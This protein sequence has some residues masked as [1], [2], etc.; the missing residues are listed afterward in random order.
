MSQS[1]QIVLV[2]HCGPDV[3]RLKTAV[4]RAVPEAEIVTVDDEQSLDEYRTPDFLW[5][6]NRILDGSFTTDSGIELIRQIRSEPAPADAPIAILISDLPGAQEE[7]IAAGAR[8]GFGKS[9]ILE[10][11]TVEILREA[12]K[13]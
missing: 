12:A 4:N 3:Y 2:G 5:L 1:R 8:P 11:R 7:A 10:E 9:Q 13:R 6:V